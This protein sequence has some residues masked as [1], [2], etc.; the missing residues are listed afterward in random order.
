MVARGPRPVGLSGG[1]SEDR[2][3]ARRG[4]EE[5]NT[6]E[7][8]LSGVRSLCVCVLAVSQHDGDVAQASGKST[9]A[10]VT[11]QIGIGVRRTKVET[12]VKKEEE[13]FQGKERR[14]GGGRDRRVGEKDLALFTKSPS[15]LLIP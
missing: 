11:V 10:Y 13:N 2:R 15:I 14:K 1:K 9:K 5:E 8:D 7:E 3:G 4:R 6:G 12:I